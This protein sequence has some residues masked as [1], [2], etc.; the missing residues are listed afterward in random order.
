MA[1]STYTTTK[2]D[3][4]TFY[5]GTADSSTV[6]IQPA[7]SDDDVWL[8]VNGTDGMFLTRDQARRFARALLEA[9]DA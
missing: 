3:L 7:D 4:L 5:R 9:A 8:Q 2:S 1:R 6:E